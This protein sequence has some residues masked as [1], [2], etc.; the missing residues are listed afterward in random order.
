[1]YKSIEAISLKNCD[2][3]QTSF[4]L[5]DILP[6]PVGTVS[7]IASEGGLGKT[8]LSIRLASRYCSETHKRA[9][10]WFSEDAQNII[11]NRYD[12]MKKQGMIID[13]TQ[14]L[15]DYV[16]TE[17]IQFAKLEKGIFK[18]NYEAL[19][20]LRKDCIVNN[21]GLVIID[22]LLAF[23]GGDEN[24]NSQARVFMQPFLEWAKKD[25][26][27]I[28]FIHHASKG[29]GK[30]RGAGAFRD[31]IRTLYEMRYIKTTKDDIDFD[32]K[33]NGLRN[34]VLAKDNLGAFSVFSKLYGGGVTEM[35]VLPRREPTV[36]VIRYNDKISDDFKL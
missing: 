35:Q 16:A 17:P 31:A 23:Y 28:V 29:E 12:Y 18:A 27:T 7:M 30:T 9:L 6:I 22:P 36:E 25:K 1:M 13:D 26:V 34:V 11:A 20:E 19:A 4:I 10:C 14:H 5:E 15:I 3:T 8:F 21:V 2:R 32:K 33:D 24:N